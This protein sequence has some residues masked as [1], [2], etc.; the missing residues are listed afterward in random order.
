MKL[1]HSLNR[2]YINYYT[3]SK[4]NFFAL[5]NSGMKWVKQEGSTTVIIVIPKIGHEVVDSF[6]TWYAFL[7]MQI[8]DLRLYHALCVLF[9]DQEL[10]KALIEAMFPSKCLSQISVEKISC[11]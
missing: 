9:A 11:F 4:S 3:L 10:Q 6:T 7:H 5:L 1:I 2:T 8:G